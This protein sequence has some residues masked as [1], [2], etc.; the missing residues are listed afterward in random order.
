M[1]TMTSTLARKSDVYLNRLSPERVERLAGKIM[2]QQEK[3]YGQEKKFQRQFQKI[4]RIQEEQPVNIMF[5]MDFIA[6]LREEYSKGS[7][8]LALMEVLPYGTTRA[9][10][11]MEISSQD[12]MLEE[13]GRRFNS[14][15][16]KVKSTKLNTS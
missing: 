5:L 14:S 10:N 4:R 15:L 6:A 8:K 7:P 9:K 13:L 2:G 11:L 16:Q 3:I 1:G 12:D